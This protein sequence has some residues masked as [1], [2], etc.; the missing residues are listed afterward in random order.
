MKW[1]EEQFS[2][3][4]VSTFSFLIDHSFNEPNFHSFN[5]PI[6][7]SADHIDQWNKIIEQ[8]GSPSQDF[9]RRLQPTV[10]C[11]TQ[12]FLSPFSTSMTT[13]SSL[14]FQVRNY[15]ENR[16]RY[17][18]Y[19]FERLFPDILFPGRYRQNPVTE[20]MV[21]FSFQPIHRNTTNWRRARQEI[22]CLKCW[23]LIQSIEFRSKKH[24]M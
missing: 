9:M 4:A 14:L 12:Y 6:F 5:E 20:L 21:W 11:F 2:F 3:Q 13:I 1:S 10:S 17:A 19:N 15:V 16:P 7:Y 23:S 24:S 22:C 8:L 18:G